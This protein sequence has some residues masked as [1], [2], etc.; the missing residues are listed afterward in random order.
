MEHIQPDPEILIAEIE[1]E[2]CVCGFSHFMR[3]FNTRNHIV[4]SANALL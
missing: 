2:I 1:V 3:A 4:S